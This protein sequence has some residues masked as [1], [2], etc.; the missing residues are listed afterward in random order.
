VENEAPTDPVTEVSIDD[1]IRNYL[2]SEE[3]GGADVEDEVSQEAQPEE[4]PGE[5]PQT[6]PEQEYDEIKWNGET[7][8]LTRA[9]IR[10]LAEKGFDYTQKTTTLAEQRRAL[11]AQQQQVE[12]SLAMQAA[13][14]DALAEVRSLDSRLQAFKDVDWVSLADQDPVQY[15]KLNQTYRDLKE[16]RDT[17]VSEFQNAAVQIQQQQAQRQSEYLA[18]ERES[19][20]SKI[21]EFGKDAQAT[22]T[23]LKEYLSSSGFKPEEIGSVSDHRAVV[24]AWKAM[25][26]DALQ[27]KK[28]ETTKKVADLP[29]VVKP[30]ASNPKAA[31]EASK[32]NQLR[33]QLR[34]TGKIPPGLLSRFV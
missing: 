6:E 11:E 29:K 2:A 10:E 14:L 30:G 7:K 15:L 1:R 16:S 13:Q 9:E 22:Q 26:Y 8:R 12:Q 31:Q 24:M 25:Q 28:V 20:I 27:S 32:Q 3:S 21:P 4:A 17:K 5:E 23:K 33:Q 34:K 19:L 18:R